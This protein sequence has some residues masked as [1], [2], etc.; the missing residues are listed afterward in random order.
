MAAAPI[1]ALQDIRL[2]L[3]ST[4]LLD[5]RRAFGGARRQDRAGRPQR[6]GQIDAA[7]DRGRRRSKPM[8]ASASCSRAPP[9]AI[10]RRSRTSPAS[11]RRSTYVDARARG[12]QRSVSRALSAASSSAS[13]A[14]EDP[15]RLS[16]GEAR[17]AALARVL[18][19]EPDILLLDEP[20]NH[21]DLP[22]IEW[23]EA[24]LAAL[25]SALVHHQPRPPLP[26]RPARA[27]RSGSTAARR[28]AST[29]ASRAF[30]EWRDTVLEEEELAR[31]KL[32]R[33]I[34]RE[35]HW[36]TLRRHRAPQAQR[37]PAAELADLRQEAP[38]RRSAP[39]ATVEARRQPRPTC[40]AR[41]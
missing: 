5:G 25:R 7:E 37:P 2:T 1:L 14:R 28:A 24:E 15:S 20:T 9:S 35:E 38:R 36:L 10:C 19:P 26:R 11:P 29:G 23:L 41:W 12:R 21:L 34:V 22:A 3:G 30:E 39:S 40:R 18:A 32:D 8:A 33:Q 31:H 16:G 4:P 6:V 27:P 17:R 13:A